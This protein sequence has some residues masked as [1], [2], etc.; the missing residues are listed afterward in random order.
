[1]FM[2]CEFGSGKKL[3]QATDEEYARYTD[4]L[5][6]KSKERQLSGEINGERFGFSGLIYMQEIPDRSPRAGIVSKITYFDAAGRSNTEETLELAK[7]RALERNIKTVIIASIRGETAQQAIKVFKDTDISLIFATCNA[8]EGC[9]RFSRETWQ[10]AEQ[11]GYKVIYT[12]ED[13]IPFPPDAVL[14][15]RRICEGMKVCVQITMSAVD[16]GCISPNSRII[17]IAGTGGKSYRAGWGADTAVVIDAVNSA[18]FFTQPRT[19]KDLKLYAQKI[20]E[21][22]CMPG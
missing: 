5:S 6:K 21:I 14:A 18:D 2:I 3:R 12:N 1:M 13:T 22:I 9:D 19:M 8:C 15:Y 4:E 17:A 16:Q 11:A 10:E 20:R 7:E